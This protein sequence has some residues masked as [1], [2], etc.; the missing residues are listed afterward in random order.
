MSTDPH[1][2]RRLGRWTPRFPRDT[3]PRPT[4]TP[5]GVVLLG[6][7]IIMVGVRLLYLHVPAGRDEA[8]YLIVGTHWDDS[9]SLYGPYWV[10]RPPLL[11]W[12]MQLVGD[13]RTL[14]I[15]GLLSGVA[16]V[17][18]VA[19]AASLAGGARAAGWA[20]GAAALFASAGWLGIA[21]TNGEMLAAP[22]VAWGLALTVQA[23]VRPG[24]RGWLLALGAGVLAAGAA[25]IK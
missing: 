25:L 8:G 23:I 1:S 12:I 21:R 3:A 4:P 6:A 11:I 13:L 18:G 14:R 9:T 5:L 15:I 20:A 16:M 2:P 17:L 19:R 24:R 7:L 10:D 22:C